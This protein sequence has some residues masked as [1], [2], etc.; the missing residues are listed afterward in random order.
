MLELKTMNPKEHEWLNK[1][2]ANHWARSYFLEYIREYCMKRI[3]NVQGVIDKCIGPLIPTTTKIRESIKKEAHLIKVQWNRAN[4]FQVSGSLS[5]QCVVDVVS[6]TTLKN[7]GNSLLLV[8]YMEGNI[9][10]Q[11]TTN[12]WDQVLGEVHMSNNTFATQASCQGY[13]D[14]FDVGDNNAEA[15]ASACRQAQETKPA[16][17]QDGSVG[18]GVDAV[19][20]LLAATGEGGANGPGGACVASQGEKMKT[21]ES[22][23]CS[24]G[25]RLCKPLLCGGGGYLRDY[26]RIVAWMDDRGGGGGYL[27][28]YVRIVAWMDDRGFGW[29]WLSQ[30]ECEDCWWDKLRGIIPSHAGIVQT[31][32]LR[33]LVDTQEGGEESVMSTQEYVRKVIEDVGEDDNFLRVSHGLA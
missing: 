21:L 24:Y 25:I 29:W 16:V 2:P 28:D 32:K 8:L 27:R 33:K 3:M 20:G 17:G 5:D 19:I 6:D 4:K 30:G 31:A 23:N 10:P 14:F 13:E 12:L 18:S 7:L 26:V 15:S 11:D 1:I 22:I 9:L